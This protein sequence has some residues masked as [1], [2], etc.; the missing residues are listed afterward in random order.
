MCPADERG[1]AAGIQAAFLNTGFVLSIGIFF[2][3]MIIG[4]TNTLP[5]AMFKGL[6]AH[7]VARD[8]GARDREPAAGRQSVLRVPRQEPAEE[9]PRLPGDGAR[10]SRA[11]AVLTGKHF[12]PDLIESL[13]PPRPRDR[14]RRGHRDV[15]HRRAR[16]GAAWQALRP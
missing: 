10:Q 9:P 5:K 3:L 6:S 14:L 7:G 1:G 11:V 16:L 2:S 15:H 13:V 12:F 8:P 4:L